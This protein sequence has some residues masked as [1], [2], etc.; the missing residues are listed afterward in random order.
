MTLA[1]LKRLFAGFAATALLAMA[2]VA[3]AAKPAAALPGD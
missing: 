2:T 3:S 1:S